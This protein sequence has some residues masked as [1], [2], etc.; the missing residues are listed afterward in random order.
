MKRANNTFSSFFRSALSPP[1]NFSSLFALLLLP[2]SHL[3]FRRGGEN[4]NLCIKP[5]ESFDFHYSLHATAF[6][7]SDKNHREFFPLIFIYKML[8]HLTPKLRLKERLTSFQRRFI[9]ANVNPYI[10]RDLFIK[11]IIGRMSKR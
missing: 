5:L 8:Y 9:L 4:G 2:Q 11:S 10:R 3:F 7:A 6:S 1:K